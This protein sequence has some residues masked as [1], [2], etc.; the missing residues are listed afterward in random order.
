MSNPFKE[1]LPPVR[2]TV[3]LMLDEEQ[4][5]AINSMQIDVERRTGYSPSLKELVMIALV[6]MYDRMQSDSM[7]GHGQ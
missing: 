6:E 5:D 4:E 7:K 2:R 1:K 3:T